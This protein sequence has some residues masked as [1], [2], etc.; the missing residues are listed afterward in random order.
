MQER[1][2]AVMAVAVMLSV[3]AGVGRGQAAAQSK[4]LVNADIVKM[5]K[6]E[7]AEDTI[8]LAIRNKP[9]S[10]DTSRKN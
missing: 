10:F 7:L 5:V 6:A 4:P 3:F 2:A 9:S 8:V 1:F